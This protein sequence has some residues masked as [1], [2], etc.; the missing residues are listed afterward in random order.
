MKIKT[1]LLIFLL[2]CLF[3]VN[4]VSLIT[5]RIEGTVLDG[6]NEVPIP[7][8]K[9]AL[10]KCILTDIGISCQMINHTE[11]N[12]NGKFKFD[13]ILQGEYFLSVFKEGYGAFGPLFN[14]YKIF[15]S[16]SYSGPMGSAV[17]T[18]NPDEIKRFN[19]KEGQIKHFMIKIEKEAIL[20]VNIKQTLPN[21]IEISPKS[22]NRIIVKHHDFL[23]KDLEYIGIY[24]AGYQSLYFRKGLVSVEIWPL[25]YP[26]KSFENILLQSGET[27]TIDYIINYTQDQVL[28]GF[29]KDKSSKEPL[30]LV[31]VFLSNPITN[32]IASK[33][34]TDKDGEFLIGG[35][36]PGKYIL[37]IYYSRTKKIDHEE[38]I[39]IKQNEKKEIIREF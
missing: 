34:L 29:I 22:L 10:F 23:D 36:E 5:S 32:R 17:C 26:L 31:E 12:N 6:E 16:L 33:T 1:V 24:P 30:E 3:R 9:I 4:L 38:I 39:E 15:V 19:I 20:K 14:Y 21:G 27:T 28:H 25:G 7:K 37:W 18:K 8:A 35:I 11:T 13:D 2:L